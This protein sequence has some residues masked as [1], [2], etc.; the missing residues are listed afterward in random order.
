M[1]ATELC[2]L[3]NSWAV[4]LI[5][6]FLSCNDSSANFSVTHGGHLGQEHR[7]LYGT[8]VQNYTTRMLALH[9]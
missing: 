4:P 9:I 6:V 8:G 2:K 3:L 7:C 1:P 5:E